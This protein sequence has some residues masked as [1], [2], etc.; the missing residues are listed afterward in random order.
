MTTDDRQI[1]GMT[2]LHMAAVK[3][4]VELARLLLLH[5]EIDVNAVDSEEGLTPLYAACSYGHVEVVKIFLLDGRVDV[6]K[7]D[8]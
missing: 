6:N 7:A 5:P 8:N 3:G 1:E 4:N 2:A